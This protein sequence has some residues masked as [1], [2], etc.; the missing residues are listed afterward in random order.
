MIH[1]LCTNCRKALKAQD[2]SSGKKCQCKCGTINR[3]PVRQSPASPPADL[4]TPP[5]PKPAAPLAQLAP[6]IAQPA[7][8]APV[9]TTPLAVAPIPF[10]EE[11][12]IPHLPEFEVFD[13]YAARP[14]TN[15]ARPRVQ[16][17]NPP[18]S[19]TIPKSPNDSNTH[20]LSGLGTFLLWAG[21]LGALYFLFLFD[22]SVAVDRQAAYYLGTNRVHN[23]GLMNDRQAGI[24]ASVGAAILGALLVKVG[25]KK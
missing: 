19:P 6:P 9:S 18:A 2:A 11:R 1:F 13:D 10:H 23:I 21:I 15:V 25:S 5:T 17:Q 8:L 12:T 20:S 3:I 22:T 7:T 14:A 16:E 24:I 4:P